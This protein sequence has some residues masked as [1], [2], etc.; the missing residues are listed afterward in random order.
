MLLTFVDRD[1]TS[2]P[3]QNGG[4][5]R[6]SGQGNQCVCPPGWTG[7]MC[8]HGQ[9]LF[10]TVKIISLISYQATSDLINASFP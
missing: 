4:V 8:E 7:H 10:L 6:N 2:Q 3:C 5:C 1:C 9:Y